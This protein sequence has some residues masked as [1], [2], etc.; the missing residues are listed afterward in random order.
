M[1][2]NEVKEWLQKRKMYPSALATQLGISRSLVYMWI[3]GD[4]KI[5]AWLPLALAQIEQASKSGPE[6]GDGER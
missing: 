4:R 3:Y 1:Q 5:P 6:V 2:P